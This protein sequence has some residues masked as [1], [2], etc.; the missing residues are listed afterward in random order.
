[1]GI[2][3]AESQAALALT[4]LL[5]HTDA[6][7]VEW[8]PPMMKIN[9]LLADEWNYKHKNNPVPENVERRMDD[10]AAWLEKLAIEPGETKPTHCVNPKINPNKVVL[11]R[12][13]HCGTPSAV[14]RR[15]KCGK[16]R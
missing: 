9:Q 6:G 3:P 7:N 8:G 15:C 13:T 1:M 16:V 11:H 5:K 2:S 10:L 12:C 14:L 4:T